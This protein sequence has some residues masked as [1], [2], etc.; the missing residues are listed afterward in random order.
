MTRFS[1]RSWMMFSV[2]S[3]LVG[4]LAYRLVDLHVL[5]QQFLR[6]QGDARTLRTIPISAHRG[7]IA[8]RNGEPLAVSAPVAS[9][10]VNPQVFPT[11]NDSVVQLAESLE[12]STDYIHKRLDSQAKKEFVYLKRQ[13]DP[14]SVQKIQSLKLPGVFIEREYRRY[15]P[16]GEIAAHVLGFTDIDGEGQEG[17][18]LAFDKDLSGAPGARRVVKDRIGRVVDEIQHLRDPKPGE[19]LYLSIDRRVQYLAYREL[20]KAVYENKAKAASLVAMDVRTGEILA[21]VNYPSF[22]PN[23]RTNHTPDTKRNRAV[24]DVFEPG[25]VIK[26]FSM[27]AALETGSVAPDT[28]VDTSPGR[29]PVRGRMVQDVNNFG[30]I[31][32][33]GIL[34]HSSNVG[35]TQVILNTPFDHYINVLNRFGF[36]V[37]TASGFPG[38]RAG[39]MNIPKDHDLH[40]QATLSFGYG[41][42]ATTLQ[43]AQAYATIANNGN[44]VPATFLRVNE[45]PEGKVVL[46]PQL[47]Q[48]LRTMLTHVVHDD[49]GV[50]RARISGYQVAGKSGTVR[51]ATVEG[52]Y[53]AKQYMSVFVGF[54]PASD[55]HIVLAVVID[56]PQAGAYY[57]GAVAA[58]VFREVMTGSLRLLD[59]TPDAVN[60]ELQL[61]QN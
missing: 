5:D 23:S 36:G 18:E 26:T 8:D 25:S 17:L 31:D 46:D 41:M 4:G 42:S 45:I 11:N 38:E 50:S 37:P 30:V 40:S 48:Q 47:A 33:T 27:I 2:L 56:E 20:L 51:K 14:Y 58:P 7:I 57:G 3:V 43:L 10:W 16:T 19:N 59:I 13:L 52:G 34:R 6:S 22:N 32:M 1:S 44:Y 24:T 9:V 61:V 54:A 55:P 49:R 21:M 53:E 35:I 12:I 39:G 60:S 29:M 28:I 15:Y